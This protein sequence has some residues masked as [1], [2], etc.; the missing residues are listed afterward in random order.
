MEIFYFT[1]IKGYFELKL[2]I[3]SEGIRDLFYIL[4]KGHYR[5]PLS[6]SKLKE[7]SS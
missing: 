3:H 7:T 1:E 6:L 5:T 4:W 2:D